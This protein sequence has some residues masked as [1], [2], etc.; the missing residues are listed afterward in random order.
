MPPST[1]PTLRQQ[2][3]GIELRKLREHAGLTSTGA[4]ALLGISQARISSIE[5]GRYPV[6][7]ER[8]RAFAR[9]YDCADEALVEALCAMTG[10]RTRGWWDECREYLPAAL[11]DLAELEHHARELRVALVIHIPALLQT[12]DHARVLF[13][14]VAPP[15]LPYEVEHRLSHRIKR[16]GI[17]YSDQPVRY[18]ALIHEAALRMGFGGRE[19]ARAQLRHIIEMSERDNITVRVLPFGG[20]AFPG[21]GQSIDYASGPV[22][23]LD[24]VQ[25]DTH[26]GCEF[27]DAEAQLVKFRSV[28]DRV[29]GAAIKPAES[30]DF[31]H[32]LVQEI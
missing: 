21:T 10:G 2:R 18:T 11:V 13:R 17:L 16:Q 14:E 9:S 5:S 26:F 31:I 8:V 32:R 19:V 22:P 3:L 25:V 23:Q 20:S 24:T 30:R 12:T 28:L 1:T 29:E 15:L 6:S 7:A 27:L 4:A